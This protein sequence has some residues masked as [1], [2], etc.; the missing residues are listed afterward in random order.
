MKGGEGVSRPG[1]VVEGLGHH[2]QVLEEGEASHIPEISV[3]VLARMTH[4]SLV[5][6]TKGLRV[7]L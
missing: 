7:T 1:L 6:E 4:C 5:K 3:A 2:C